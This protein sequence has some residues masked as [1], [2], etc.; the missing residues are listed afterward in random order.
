VARRVADRRGRGLAASREVSQNKG[1]DRP[2]SGSVSDRRNPSAK[3]GMKALQ[4]V[5]MRRIDRLYQREA[6][7]IAQGLC[8]IP[9]HMLVELA[10]PF[11]SFEVVVSRQPLPDGDRR[12]PVPLVAMQP[13]K[14]VRAGR[15]Q[16]RACST[17]SAVA[18]APRSR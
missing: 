8:K 14:L 11:Q 4:P 12:R 16:A 17:A 6:F 7:S 15:T 13:R 9:A 2:A 18:T 1:A 5:P 10:Q 3:P